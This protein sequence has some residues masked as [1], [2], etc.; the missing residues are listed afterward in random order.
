MYK[1]LNRPIS[2]HL[3]IYSAQKS[4]LSSIWHRFSAIVLLTLFIFFLFNC[5]LII[6]NFESI[7]ILKG[8]LVMWK[9][10]FS[11]P[12]ELLFFLSLIYHILNGFRHIG[13]D[14]IQFLNNKQL[15]FSF[16]IICSCI[17]FLLLTYTL[18]L[19]I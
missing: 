16:Y 11:I 1:L 10:S 9:Y 7:L 3:T 6:W 5:K 4:S 13:W 15:N 18:I 12:I 14:L 8:C 19:Y 17:L 2:P